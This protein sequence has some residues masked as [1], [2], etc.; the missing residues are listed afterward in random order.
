ME[1]QYVPMGD[2]VGLIT[3]RG[4]RLTSSMVRGLSLGGRIVS[5]VA[6]EDGGIGAGVEDWYGNR[7]RLRQREDAKLQALYRVRD[8]LD[9][10]LE[11]KDAEPQAA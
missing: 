1:E 2:L 11:R 5:G 10:I 3:G 8:V 7:V 9:V 4:Q 6:I